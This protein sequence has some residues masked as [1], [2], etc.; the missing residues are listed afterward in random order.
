MSERWIRRGIKIATI[1]MLAIAVC[2]F[3]VM[4]LWNWLAPAIFGGRTID[5]WQALGIIVL[6]KILFGGFRG[7]PGFGGHWRSR[8]RERWEKM[9]PEEREKFCRGMA[10]RC[11]RGAGLAEESSAPGSV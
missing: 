9:T 4:G 11:G 6:S 1:G 8:M 5:F 10:S 7:R 3:V 2:G